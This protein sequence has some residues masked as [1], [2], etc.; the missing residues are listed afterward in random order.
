MQGSLTGGSVEQCWIGFSIGCAKKLLFP[1]PHSQLKQTPTGGATSATHA[2]PRGSGALLCA[3]MP[4]WQPPVHVTHVGLTQPLHLTWSIIR[5]LLLQCMVLGRRPGRAGPNLFAVVVYMLP[6]INILLSNL[7]AV[8]VYMVVYM[9]HFST[10]HGFGSNLFAVVVHRCSAVCT[11][12]SLDL[13]VHVGHVVLVNS[14]S[15]GCPWML[16]CLQMSKPGIPYWPALTPQAKI[17]I[18][19]S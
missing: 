5:S 2:P 3:L 16:C 9:L 14:Q 8:V 17:F 11:G 15:G 4:A 18:I 13:P 7:F 1:H 19:V 6:V 12:A 10:M